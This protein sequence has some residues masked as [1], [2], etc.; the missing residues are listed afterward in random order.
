MKTQI[1]HFDGVF[2]LSGQGRRGP[3][4]VSL[5]SFKVN[6]QA[7]QTDLSKGFPDGDAALWG[8]ALITFMLWYKRCT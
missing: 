6:G 8:I 3:C 1:T 2:G 4:G 5:E 7:F